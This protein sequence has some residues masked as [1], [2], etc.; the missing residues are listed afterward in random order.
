MHNKYAFIFWYGSMK[1]M[2]QATRPI[3]N[4]VVQF[5]DKL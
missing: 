4:K 2:P 5:L 1:G 3:P